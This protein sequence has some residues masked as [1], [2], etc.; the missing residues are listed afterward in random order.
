MYA[1]QDLDWEQGLAAVGNAP[2]VDIEKRYFVAFHEAPQSRGGQKEVFATERIQFSREAVRI[3]FTIHYDFRTLWNGY[4]IKL[5]RPEDILHIQKLA[6]VKATHPVE[7]L[8]LS[9][10]AKVERLDMASAISMTFVDSVH[11]ELAF[12]GQGIRVG[13]IDSGIDYHHPDLGGCFGPMCRVAFG[14][15]FVGNNFRSGSAVQPDADPDDQRGHGTHVAGIIGANGGVIG[16]APEVT[17]GAYKVFGS[18]GTT[19]SDI[20]IAALERAYLDQMDV[21]NA[22]LGS[23]FG[24]SDGPH[25]TA[26][27]NLIQA[28]TVMVASAGNADELGLQAV[29]NLG[30]IREAISV[31]SFDNTLIQF[32]TATTSLGNQD[33]LHLPLWGTANPQPPLLDGTYRMQKTVPRHGCV[34]LPAGSLNGRVVLM[35]RG[36]GCNYYNKAV[37]AQNAG[38]VALLIYNNR[39]GRTWTI[40]FD[41]NP[42]I[43]IPVS[44]I[45]GA[46]GNA[47]R[48]ALT[49]GSTITIGFK[50][51]FGFEAHS[52]AAKASNFSSYGP[53]V[54]LDFKPDLGAPGGRV[55]STFPLEQGGYKTAQ[56]TSMSSPHVAGIVALI[57]EAHPNLSP[58]QI[59]SRLRNTAEPKT[60]PSARAVAGFLDHVH[61]QGA[62]LANAKRAIE[63]K[64]EIEP[65]AISLGELESGSR[66]ETF[67]ITNSSST[68]VRLQLSHVPALSST[69]SP[70]SRSFSAAA[71]LV[72]ISP[73]SIEI[74]AGTSAQITLEISAPPQL[75]EHTVFGGFILVENQDSQARFHLPFMGF[76]GDYQRVN[77]LVPTSENYPWL[78]RKPDFINLPTGAAY[79]FVD[80]DE[81][82]VLFYL[83]WPVDRARIEVEWDGLFRGP[84]GRSRIDPTRDDDFS[85]YSWSGFVRIEGDSFEVPD[86]RYNA[87]FGVLRVLGD[88]SV[89]ADW[90]YE[91]LPPITLDRENRGPTFP[92][93]EPAVF[94][95][96]D[97]II[98]DFSAS[99]INRDT[100][101]YQ[102]L[103]VPMGAQFDTNTGRLTWDTGFFDEGLYHLSLSVSDGQ[104]SA[105]ASVSMLVQD[106]NQAPVIMPVGLIT[107]KEG[108]QLTQQFTAV[109]LDGEPVYFSLTSTPSGAVIGSSNGLFIWDV[110][111]NQAGQ[112]LLRIQAS[113]GMLVSSITATVSIENINRPPVVSP[114]ADLTISEKETLKF[115]INATDPD[116]DALVFTA[117]NLP[118]GA[119]LNGKGQFSWTPT[120]AQGGV[121]EFV[122]RV[123]DGESTV[124]EALKITVIDIGD[125]PRMFSTAEK[126]ACRCQSSPMALSDSLGLFWIPLALLAI[127]RKKTLA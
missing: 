1:C 38:A 120:F 121:H 89:P 72:Q 23:S 69:T 92:S 16:V 100:L 35:R 55:R 6:S 43:A 56:G 74:P 3:E 87:R 111:Y 41:G 88:P 2:K 96:G 44:M 11:Q 54:S 65:S 9:E 75:A 106:V 5:A 77:A 81:P 122:L 63:A 7:I 76:K 21:V 24:W 68:S 13:V 108:E 14:F 82:T 91:A 114:I 67:T 48:G 124:G 50:S 20:T 46:D 25:S 110:N 118:E 34:A 73:T 98:L 97:S 109:D 123:G 37:N 90:Q 18:D 125:P 86:G 31:A 84:D 12:R 93:F 30:S 83:D 62:G 71:A 10:E 17:F 8:T 61:L 116:G 51:E 85:S 102:C 36:G 42:V 104:E 112:H 127:R 27:Q 103:G 58:A 115:T 40:N 126:S 99:D 15:D 79:S 105:Y 80:D 60:P 57:K 53:N 49:S 70:H 107:G 66:S 45:S 33:L 95:E 64:I 78:V 113:D 119:E 52:N 59:K 28:G 47:L 94:D 101:S 29:S 22:S 19:R 26:I 39:S 4:S 32:R 117:Q